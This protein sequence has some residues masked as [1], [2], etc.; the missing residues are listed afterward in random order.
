MKLLLDTTYF[1]PTI[2]VSIKEMQRDALLMLI[3]KEHKIAMSQITIFELTAK[4]AKYI[5]EGQL[6][7][8]RVTRGI[9][10]IVYNDAIE[11][12]PT[13]DTS[14]LLTSFKLR[15]MLNDFIDCLILSSAMNHCDAIITEDNEIQSLKKNTEFNNLVAD[16]NPV[17]KILKLTE[18]I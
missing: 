2:G 8:E 15:N 12:I 11:T 9:R 17:F 18:I 1:L 4:G 7:P 16:Q 5:K 10:A 3:A 14:I 6:T 13:H